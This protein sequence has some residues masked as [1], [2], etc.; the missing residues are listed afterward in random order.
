MG[1]DGFHSPM[2]GYS[3][4]NESCA[5][6]AMEINFAFSAFICNVKGIDKIR[7]PMKQNAIGAMLHD[8]KEISNATGPS[9]TITPNLIIKVPGCIVVEWA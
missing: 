9:N 6:S 7:P 1:E 5:F 3:G 2:K 8:S 4:L